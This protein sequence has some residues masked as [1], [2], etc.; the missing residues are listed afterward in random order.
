MTQIPQAAGIT[1]G[2]F[3][4]FGQEQ[5]LAAGKENPFTNL[6]DRPRSDSDYSHGVAPC[7]S[8]CVQCRVPLLSYV[9]GCGCGLG[10]GMPR[11]VCV[12]DGAAA[13]ASRISVRT[14]CFCCCR[15][16]RQFV[17]PA[18]AGSY[19]GTAARVG[20]AAASSSAARIAAARACSL[21]RQWSRCECTPCQ[22]C[23]H[24][25]SGVLRAAAGG[26]SAAGGRSPTDR[27]QEQRPWGAAF[28]ANIGVPE[29]VAGDGSLSA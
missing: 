18:T 28:G 4:K 23:D 10:C 29:R 24:G 11:A 3:N 1:G 26:S 20:A 5:G 21:R 2:Q 17:A 9:H 14:E 22:Q 27:R 19:P 15:L 6:N 7:P 16:S 12:V 8:R 25:P 13:V